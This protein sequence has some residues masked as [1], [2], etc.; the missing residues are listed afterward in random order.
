MAVLRYMVASHD[1]L[2]AILFCVQLVSVPTL[3]RENVARSL[4]FN[5]AQQPP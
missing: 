3:I 5:N 1:F 4:L 2:D